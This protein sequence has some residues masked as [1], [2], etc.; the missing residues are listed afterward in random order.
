MVILEREGY[1]SL[2]LLTRDTATLSCRRT[3]VTR[4]PVPLLGKTMVAIAVAVY[5]WDFGEPRHKIAALKGPV[6]PLLVGKLP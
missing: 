5:I 1:C 6:G 4:K 3:A 2:G